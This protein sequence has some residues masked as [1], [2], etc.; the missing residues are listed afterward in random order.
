LDD[1][2]SAVDAQ[3]GK[4]IFD[5]LLGSNG[6]LKNKVRVMFRKLVIYIALERSHFKGLK[7]QYTLS[8]SS[9]A[10]CDRCY[11]GVV[12]PSVRMYTVVQ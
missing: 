4:H 5:E 10:S 12:C 9:S 11:H 8:G 3:V 6:L 1:P 7:D 2:L